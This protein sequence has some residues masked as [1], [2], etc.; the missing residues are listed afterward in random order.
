MFEQKT[1]GNLI[2]KISSNVQTIQ[3][4]SISLS[5][6]YGK[7]LL[8]AFVGLVMI[9][10]SLNAEAYSGHRYRSGYGYRSVYS[11]HFGHR[12]HSGYPYHYG[13]IYSGYGYYP[14]YSDGS[15]P[16]IE[17]VEDGDILAVKSFVKN[18]AN[19]NDKNDD[20]ETA[21]MIAADEGHTAVAQL[22]RDAGA[23]E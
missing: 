15:D 14:I 12:Y 6:C 19:I 11:H 5:N 1:R 10:A 17:S 4:K 22:L 8:A 13:R 21:L 20:D 18:G 16:F 9:G 2:G 3:P 23:T 7:A